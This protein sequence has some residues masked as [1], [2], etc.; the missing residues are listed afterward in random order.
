M[1]NYGFGTST[2]WGES[3]T[4]TCQGI[5]QNLP[6]VSGMFIGVIPP[7]PGVGGLRPLVVWGIMTP[8]AEDVLITDGE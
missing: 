4:P 7:I 1:N 3:Q 5:K 6:L 8:E 2:F